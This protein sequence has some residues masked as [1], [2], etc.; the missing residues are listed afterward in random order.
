MTITTIATGAYKLIVGFK[1]A[2]D[3]FFAIQNIYYDN[4]FER[5]SNEVNDLKGRRRALSNSIENANSDDDRRHLSILLAELQ[6]REA[7]GH[8][9][10]TGEA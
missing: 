7:D 4:L 6:L 10:D 3:L 9:E 5:L 2:R 8:R 1:A